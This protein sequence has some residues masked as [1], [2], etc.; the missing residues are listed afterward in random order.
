MGGVKRMLPDDWGQEGPNEEE[1]TQLWKMLRSNPDKK[2]ICVGT[3]KIEAEWLQRWYK[4]PHD[5]C[6]FFSSQN[7]WAKL[8]KNIPNVDYLVLR[9]LPK[10]TDYVHHL[11]ILKTE[12]LLIGGK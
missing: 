2:Y 6:I 5:E 7:D 9:P 11:K 4:V 8:L 12:H 10:G 3:N 1:E